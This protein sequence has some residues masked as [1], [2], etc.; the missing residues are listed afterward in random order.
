MLNMRQPSAPLETSFL[1]RN[2]TFLQ[3][4]DSYHRIAS[5][6]ETTGGTFANAAIRGGA[7][8]V[9]SCYFQMHGVLLRCPF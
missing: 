3:N 7:V 2:S 1:V 4:G 6:K 5:W 9:D 8:M